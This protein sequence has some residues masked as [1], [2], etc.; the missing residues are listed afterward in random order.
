MAQ[1]SGTLLGISC[2]DQVDLSK[3]LQTH[4]LP[5]LYQ[6]CLGINSIRCY[7]VGC[8]FWTFPL[9]LLLH[10]KQSIA[11]WLCCAQQP[12]PPLLSSPA[13]PSGANTTFP[14]CSTGKAWS[15][16]SGKI[17]LYLTGHV[18]KQCPIVYTSHLFLAVLWNFYGIQVRPNFK[19]RVQLNKLRHKMGGNAGNHILDG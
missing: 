17:Q 3:W 16:W 14:H 7:F 11:C 6:H 8:N 13:F 18:P 1:S 15:R 12:C 2:K 19:G 9:G 4:T 10:Q 5:F